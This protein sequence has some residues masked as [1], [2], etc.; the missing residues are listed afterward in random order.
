MKECKKTVKQK[1]E[2]GLMKCTINQELNEFTKL[3]AEYLNKLDAYLQ[4]RANMRFDFFCGAFSSHDVLQFDCDS[5]F[6]QQN[7]THIATDFWWSCVGFSATVVVVG[8][9]TGSVTIYSYQVTDTRAKQS[10]QKLLEELKEKIEE[11]E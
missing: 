6:L 8:V 5:V 10:I 11:L 2:V 4:K 7:Q 1:I 9:K 3:F